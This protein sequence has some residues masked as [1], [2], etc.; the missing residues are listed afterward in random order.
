MA[1]EIAVRERAQALLR[2][3]AKVVEILS[4]SYEGPESHDI[5]VADRILALVSQEYPA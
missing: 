1:H 3:R 4:D 2:F 5:D